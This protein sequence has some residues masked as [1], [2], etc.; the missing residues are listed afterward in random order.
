MTR[1]WPVWLLV[2][3]PVACFCDE[4]TD[5]IIEYTTNGQVKLNILNIT[6]HTTE[7]HVTLLG[8][9]YG[10]YDYYL[11]FPPLPSW[12]TEVTPFNCREC[13]CETFES[14]RTES[15]YII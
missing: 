9:D 10:Y 2:F 6:F 1:W 8:C 11:L 14:E 5:I 13:R 12:K 3:L 15:F 7:L 4:S